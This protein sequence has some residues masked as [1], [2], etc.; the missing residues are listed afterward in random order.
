[1]SERPHPLFS[2]SFALAISHLPSVAM[3]LTLP[4]GPWP[5]HFSILSLSFLI[6]TIRIMIMMTITTI[7]MFGKSLGWARSEILI[8]STRQL[9]S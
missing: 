5:S 7:K 6:Y 3:Q 8:C 9:L 2:C 4:V 1:M